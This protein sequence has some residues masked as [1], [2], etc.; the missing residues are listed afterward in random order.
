MVHDMVANSNQQQNRLFLKIAITMGLKHYPD[1][2]T[3]VCV[4]IDD[5]VCF[6]RRL[7]SDPQKPLTVTIEPVGLLGGINKVAWCTKLPPTST[8]ALAMV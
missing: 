6:Y 8:S 4:A 2:V 5:R 3:Y 7:F 1:T